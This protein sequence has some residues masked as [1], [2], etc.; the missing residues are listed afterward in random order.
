M[1]TS[2]IP[3]KRLSP[4]SGKPW[5]PLAYQKRSIKFLL[6]RAH[7]GLLLNPGGRKT[8][9]TL[10]TLKILFTQKMIRKVL[11]IAP[12]RPCYTV[13]PGE[14]EKWSDFNH[15]TYTILHGS[16]KDEALKIDA[17]IYIINPAGLMWL[18][19]ATKTKVPKQYIDKFTGEKKF[20]MKTV[21]QIDMK[22]FKS[23]GFD[24]LVVDELTAFKNQSSDRYKLMKEVLPTFARRWGLTGSVAANGL[25]DLFG[26]CYVLDMGRTLGRFITHYRKEYFDSD[27]HE[28]NWTIK[29]GGEQRI[30]ERLAPLMLRIEPDEMGVE[31]PQLVQNIIEIEL[32]DDARRIYDDLEKKMLADINGSKFVASNAASVS[33]KCRQ[34][35][36]G[37]IFHY[38]EPVPGQ[39]QAPREM[40]QLH[41][42]KTEALLELVEELQ[43]SPILVAYDFEHDLER[44]RRA[45]PKAV[46][47]CDVEIKKFRA[48]ED[49]WNAG[50]IPVLFGHPQSIG[51]GLNLQGASHN[52]AWYTLTYDFE[53]YDQFNR[54]V[55]RSGNTTLRVFVH[56]LL[57][58]NTIDFLIYDI[59]N[60]KDKGQ[61]ALFKGLQEL[62]KG[63]R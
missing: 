59:L 49:K 21:V 23:F 46:F 55:L 16:K 38:P 50:D 27:Y 53:F 12:K 28:V 32:P 22:R 26:Q 52:V 19:G 42:A 40:V 9:I 14:I 45:F 36:S 17:Q 57:A 15:L 2:V 39:R 3:K 29:P 8:S 18:L 4:S 31:L 1:S 35:A 25:M 63:I 47:T 13:W 30:Y 61:Q 51:H 58:K 43:Q 20:T 11:V 34:V 48:V 60:A 37:G 7:G 6:E 54:R 62:A 10:A 33:S 44:L 24:V 41:D 56:H 5:K